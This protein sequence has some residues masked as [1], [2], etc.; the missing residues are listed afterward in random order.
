[1]RIGILSAV[2]MSSFLG[3]LEKI[4][5]SREQYDE[6]GNLIF[7]IMP[8]DLPH[9]HEYQ[10]VSPR[11][12]LRTGKRTDPFTEQEPFG[13]PPRKMGSEPKKMYRKRIKMVR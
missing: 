11:S 12:S 13:L 9:A 8:L 2:A 3:I 1:M 6:E 10:I 4:D 7:E 5:R